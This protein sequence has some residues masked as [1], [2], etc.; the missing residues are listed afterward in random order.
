MNLKKSS[1]KFVLSELASVPET[2]E[3]GLNSLT[4]PFPTNSIFRLQFS[5][6]SS[7][8]C[9]IRVYINVKEVAVVDLKSKSPYKGNKSIM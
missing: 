1:I 8:E 4:S 6:D 2:N 9:L 5:Y 7:A 3:D